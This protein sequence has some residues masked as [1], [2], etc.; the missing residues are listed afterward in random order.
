MCGAQ[1]T[2]H[3]CSCCWTRELILS[4]AMWYDVHQHALLCALHKVVLLALHCRTTWSTSLAVRPT[5]LIQHLLCD[6]DMLTRLGCWGLQMMESPLI[7]AA[8]N[9]H[10]QMVKFLVENRADVNA[11]DLVCCS[12]S[13]I[14]SSI[15]VMRPH[16]M[17]PAIPLKTT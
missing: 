11:I 5:I 9:G 8:H 17:M 13:L 4:S 7:R 3:V 6:P 2:R 16:L 12:T 10:F 1:V 15:T 14:A